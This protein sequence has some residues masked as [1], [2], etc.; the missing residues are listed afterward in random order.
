MTFYRLP[1]VLLAGFATLSVTLAAS[2]FGLSAEQFLAGVLG[3]GVL[4]A[5]YLAVKGRLH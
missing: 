2:A 1:R 5:A 3:G 4:T